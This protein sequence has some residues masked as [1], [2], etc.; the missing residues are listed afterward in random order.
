MVE[1]INLNN[2]EL[3]VE[4]CRVVAFNKDVDFSITAAIFLLT[5]L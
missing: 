5:S 4:D 3:F 1:V 2:I